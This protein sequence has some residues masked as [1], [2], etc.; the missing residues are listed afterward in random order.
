MLE[1]SLMKLLHKKHK[2]FTLRMME[3]LGKWSMMDV[4]LLAFLVMLLPTTLMGLTLPL[5]SRAVIEDEDGVG[6]GA[7][8]LYAA[9]TLGAVLG[10]VLA[11]FVLIPEF[12]LRVYQR[13]GSGDL[14]ALAAAVGAG[15]RPA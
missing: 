3:H 12:G 4:M 2:A 14:N 9:N 13:P 10:C 6:L 11:G 8:A 15:E 7:G 1:L 5:L